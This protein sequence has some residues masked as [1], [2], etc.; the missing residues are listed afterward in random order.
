MVLASG[1]PRRLGRPDARLTFVEAPKKEEHAAFGLRVLRLDDRDAFELSLWCGT[2][3]FLFKRL[4][5]ANE[6]LSLD[7]LSAR[8]EAGIGELDEEVI[9]AFAELL[10]EGDYVPLLLKIRPQ[11]VTPLGEG[12]YFS[13]EQ[14]AT[15]GI[16]PF[17]GLPQ[18]SQTPYYRT[19]ETAVS[20]EAHLYEF[21]VPMVPP[22]WNTPDVVTEYRERLA[23]TSE[24]T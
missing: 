13:E 7:A 21:A 12:D 6:R 10:P 20:D 5:G 16:D 4:E 24:P 23:E 3:P 22:R 14:I 11:L 8:L 15:W 9:S 2:C 1:A 17:W 19:Y 18:Y